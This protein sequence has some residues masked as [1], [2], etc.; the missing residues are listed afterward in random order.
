VELPEVI[1]LIDIGI[2]FRGVRRSFQFDDNRKNVDAGKC[3]SV[4]LD[5]TNNFGVIQDEPPK[6]KMRS[7]CQETMS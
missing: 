4:Q 1:I 3:R 2:A 7:D 5:D 6:R